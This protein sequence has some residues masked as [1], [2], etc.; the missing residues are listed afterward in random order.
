MND[1]LDISPLGRRV[2]LEPYFEEMTAGGIILPVHSKRMSDT[3]FVRAVGTGCNEALAVGDFVVLEERG[4]ESPGALL[5]TFIVVLSSPEGGEDP[6]RVDQDVEPMVK[7]HWEAYLANPSTEDRQLRV[8]DAESKDTDPWISF[9][10]SDIRDIQS[11]LTGQTGI[12]L[13]QKNYFPVPFE[14]TGEKLV[15]VDENEIMMVVSNEEEENA[16]I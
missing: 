14:W 1:R 15:F 13:Q 6:I 9:Y 3:G 4:F 10:T 7:E 5:D 2:L 8:K 16:E 12:S 11:G